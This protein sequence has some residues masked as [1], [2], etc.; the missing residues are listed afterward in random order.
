M[1]HPP[2]AIAL[3]CIHMAGTLLELPTTKWLRRIEVD[4]QEVE[5]VTATLIQM[6]DYCSTMPERELQQVKRAYSG[7]RGAQGSE[8]H[9]GTALVRASATP[10]RAMWGLPSDRSSPASGWWRELL[11]CACVSPPTACSRCTRP[12]ISCIGKGSDLGARFEA[13][14][15]ADR[16]GM[17]KR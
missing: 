4:S 9:A 11:A 8:A 13:S 12:S 3:A 16:T 17:S 5:E 15:P 2:N 6:Y 10:R 14:S 1:C 7:D